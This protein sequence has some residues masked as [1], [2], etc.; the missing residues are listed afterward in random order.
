MR[1][2]LNCLQTC[3]ICRMPSNIGNEVDDH[4]MADQLWLRTRIREEGQ[5]IRKSICSG[6]VSDSNRDTRTDSV[7]FLLSI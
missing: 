4:S 6:K 3:K 1:D 7:H 5:M 2:D